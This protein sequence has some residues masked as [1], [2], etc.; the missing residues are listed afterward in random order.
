[1]SLVDILSP[2][3]MVAAPMRTIS[4]TQR[5]RSHREDDD[6]RKK[7]IELGNAIYASALV[8]KRAGGDQEAMLE[9]VKPR[10]QEELAKRHAAYQRM[11]EATAEYNGRSI[12]I[13]VAM[14]RVRNNCAA[15]EEAESLAADAR[16]SEAAAEDARHSEAACRRHALNL[17]KAARDAANAAISEIE[18]LEEE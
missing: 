14:E 7:A 4:Q 17:A 3:R 10:F 6:S 1:M 16:H 13:N 11:V 18:A 2:G 9:A 5:Q 15:A 12:M 8:A